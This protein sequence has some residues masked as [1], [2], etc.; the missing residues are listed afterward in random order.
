LFFLFSEIQK[1][2]LFI[3][4]TFFQIKLIYREESKMEH[5]YVSRFLCKVLLQTAALYSQT[6]EHE[7]SKSIVEETIKLLFETIKNYQIFFLE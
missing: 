4:K 1:K 6:K 7:K 2:K 3:E 5:L